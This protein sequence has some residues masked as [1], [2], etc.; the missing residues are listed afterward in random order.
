MRYELDNG[1][2]SVMP[3]KPFLKTY[4]IDFI[5]MSRSAKSTNST[6]SQISGGSAG[7][8][9]VTAGN[10]ASTVVTSDTRNELMDS[11][12]KNVTDIILE[13]DR[14]KYKSQKEISSSSK[15]AAQGEGA[16]AA[17]SGAPGG[18]ETGRWRRRVRA[19]RRRFGRGQ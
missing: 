8:A 15:V 11:L 12:V 4:K 3:D 14:L 10:S 7:A 5:N 2:L 9:G 1:T 19:S 16:A 13:E 6:S 18:R 17:Y